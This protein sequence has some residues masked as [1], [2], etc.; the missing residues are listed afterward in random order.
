MTL[1]S[2][3]TVRHNLQNFKKTLF[4][5]I[6]KIQRLWKYKL[7]MLLLM[8]IIQWIFSSYSIY[9]YI[10]IYLLQWLILNGLYFH[11]P[12]FSIF[13]FLFLKLPFNDTSLFYVK[14]NKNNFVMDCI[15]FLLCRYEWNGTKQSTT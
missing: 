8:K 1:G 4:T 3:K 15:K 5:N 11:S 9:I 6:G 10:Y 13:F 2:N 14:K 12:F 7:K